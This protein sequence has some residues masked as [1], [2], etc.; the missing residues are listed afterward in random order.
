M[1]LDI[2]TRSLYISSDNKEQ[3][4]VMNGEQKFAWFFLGYYAFIA[5]SSAAN[6]FL[7]VPL[8]GDV[9]VLVTVILSFVIFFAGFFLIVVFGR[10]PAGDKVEGDERGTILSLKATFAGAMAS[11][12]AVFL[13]C[14]FTEFQFKR[15]GVDSVSVRTLTHTLNHLMGIVGFAFFGVRSIAVLILYGRG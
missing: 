13:F 9:V 2:R 12:G 1:F 11:Y 5:L 10:K 7:F 6:K 15:L 14:F 3:E 4:V 8:F